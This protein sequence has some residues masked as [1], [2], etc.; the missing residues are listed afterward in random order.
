MKKIHRMSET[1]GDDS[2]LEQEVQENIDQAVED[3]NKFNFSTLEEVKK[4][5]QQ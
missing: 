5:F 2:K 3:V 4:A 1:A